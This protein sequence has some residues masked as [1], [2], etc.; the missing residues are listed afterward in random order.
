MAVSVALSWLSKYVNTFFHFEKEAQ[1]GGAQEKE[2]RSQSGEASQTSSDREEE[3]GK[4]KMKELN[5]QKKLDALKA[6]GKERVDHYVA[7]RGFTKKTFKACP[8]ADAKAMAASLGLAVRTG[9]A[10]QSLA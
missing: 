1:G 3:S 6:E 10:G 7:E 9:K 8:M 2:T 5:A 4:K